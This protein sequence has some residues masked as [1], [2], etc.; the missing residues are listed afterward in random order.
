[1]KSTEQAPSSSLPAA[2]RSRF[3]SLRAAYLERLTGDNVRLKDLRSQ[4]DG[5][6]PPAGTL[7]EDLQ[8]IAHGMAGAASI[9]EAPRISGAA[10]ALQEAAAAAANS[11]EERTHNAVGAALDA[12]IETLRH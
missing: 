6:H 5:T 3:D 10:R 11:R 1:M 7:L 4:L 12:L 2:L 8:R 9:F